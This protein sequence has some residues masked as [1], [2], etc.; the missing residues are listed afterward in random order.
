MCVKAAGNRCIFKPSGEILKTSILDSPNPA[1]SN[2]HFYKM[3]PHILTFCQRVTKKVAKW[4]L[5][6]DLKILWYLS[7]AQII[8]QLLLS[9]SSSYV[10]WPLK[11]ITHHCSDLNHHQSGKGLTRKCMRPTS[12]IVGKLNCFRQKIFDC[13]SFPKNFRQKIPQR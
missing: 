6:K 8:M 12:N 3:Y 10:S 1:A 4:S 13:F 5:D 2:V 7:F 11:L 9:R